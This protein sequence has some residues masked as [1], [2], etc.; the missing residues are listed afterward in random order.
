MTFRGT[1]S[2]LPVN[3]NK[4]DYFK[5]AGASLDIKGPKGQKLPLGERDI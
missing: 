1:V 5:G 2:Y 3:P 4:S